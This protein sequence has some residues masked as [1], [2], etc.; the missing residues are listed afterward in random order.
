LPSIPRPVVTAAATSLLLLALGGCELLKK[1]EAVQ[2]M[3]NSRAVGAPV[4]DF[5]DRF[6]PARTRVELT[7]G[8]TGYEWQSAVESTPPG[9]ESRDQRICQLRLLADRRG[10]ITSAEIVHDG[11]GR[12]STSRCG[13]IFAPT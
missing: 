4:S 9:P 10:R 11:L 1:N 5:L 6:G 3:V 2:A 8:S 13:E 7:D 12:R